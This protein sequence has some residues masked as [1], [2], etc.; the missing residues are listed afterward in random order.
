MYTYGQLCKVWFKCA[1]SPGGPCTFVCVLD[2]LHF[3]PLD[4]YVALKSLRICV[5]PSCHCLPPARSAGKRVAS[6]E[7]AFFVVFRFLG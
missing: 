6:A 7:F 1:N 2:Q 3:L 4:N 5:A